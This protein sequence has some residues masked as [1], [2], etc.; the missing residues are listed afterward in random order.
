MHGRVSL[1][2]WA[3]G[4]SGCPAVLLQ[5]V[6]GFTDPVT[7][8]ELR[9]PIK[10]QILRELQWSMSFCEELLQHGQDCTAFLPGRGAL[11]TH[12]GFGPRALCLN[13]SRK[14]SNQR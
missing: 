4:Y 12:A 6:H 3:Y 2:L 10:H 11:L 1:G 13:L 9:H 14:G 8:E 5:R 7:V